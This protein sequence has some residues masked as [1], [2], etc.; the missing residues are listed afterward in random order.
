MRT[1]IAIPLPTGVRDKL[2]P[3]LAEFRSLSSAVRWT[4]TENL[5]LT[6]KFVGGISPAPMEE[7]TLRLH[8]T[9][10]HTP[11]FR[12]RLDGYGAFPN[13]RRPRVFWSAVRGAVRELQ[14]AQ[15]RVEL[16]CIQARVPGE[17]KPFVPHLTLGRVRDKRNL[18][19]VLEYIRIAPCP[20]EDFDVDQINIYTSELTPQGPIHSLTK[21]IRLLA[22]ES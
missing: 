22:L 15:G 16:A 13:L 4:K 17:L 8:E 10:A 21:A 2:E 18:H 5:H 3:I 20:K 7:L 1:F 12:L 9:L 11:R 14:V 19:P 6:L